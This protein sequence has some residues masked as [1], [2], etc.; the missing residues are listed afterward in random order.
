MLPIT[1]WRGETLNVQILI[2]SRD[3]LQQLRIN[4]AD[5]KGKNIQMISKRN[6]HLSLVRYVLSNYPYGAR[7]A[8][9]GE[10]SYKNLFLMPDRLEPVTPFSDR[11]DLPG[12]ST[13]PI[14]ISI[15]IPQTTA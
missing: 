10:S 1:G 9:C 11:F 3:T 14:W 6:L 5:L 7:D 8:T 2:W 15:D 12:K 4:V 13:R